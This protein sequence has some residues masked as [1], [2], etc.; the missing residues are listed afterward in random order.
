MVGICCTAMHTKKYKGEAISLDA[1]HALP[2]TGGTRGVAAKPVYMCERGGQK[3]K[4]II[5]DDNSTQ[6]SH[7]IR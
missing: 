7:W 3:Q 4:T 1:I 6:G 2:A 5:L